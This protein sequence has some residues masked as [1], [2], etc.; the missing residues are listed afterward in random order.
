MPGDTIKAGDTLL[1]IESMKMEIAVQ[2]IEAGTV[3][4]IQRA[5]GQQV[6]AG[7]CLLV[8]EIS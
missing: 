6:K 5:P 4:S 7:Q 8:L 2:A 1:I 3:L